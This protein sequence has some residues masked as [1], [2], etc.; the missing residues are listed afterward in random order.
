[1]NESRI[2][3]RY[4]KALFQS[5]LEKNLLDK[6]NQ[7]MIFIDS[8]CRMDE[9]NDLIN[10]PI[11]KPGKKQE[12]FESLLGNNVENITRSLVSLVIRNGRERYLPVITRVVNSETIRYRGITETYLTTAVPVNEDIRKNVTDLISAR[13]NTKV[14]LKETVDSDIIGGF[15]LKI[16][17]NYFDASIKNKLK[18]IR[19]ELST[20]MI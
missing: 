8:L 6:V 20:R 1:M 11:I 3:V 18:K 16:G 2:A 9:V 14:V 13:F 17:D 15:I 7:D 10:S 5:A 19:A 12:V 4:A